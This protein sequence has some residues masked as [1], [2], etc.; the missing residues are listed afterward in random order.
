MT[1]IREL[2][3]QGRDNHKFKK[4]EEAIS[5]QGEKYMMA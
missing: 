2:S 3:S 4:V 1:Q 5:M